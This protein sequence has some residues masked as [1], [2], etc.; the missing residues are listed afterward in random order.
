MPTATVIEIPN[1]G[2]GT[3]LKDIFIAL[4]RSAPGCWTCNGRALQM[5]VWGVD[6]CR[7]HIEEIVAWV[8]EEY[9]KLGRIDTA[10]AVI[11]AATTGLAFS[12]DPRDPPRSLV[13]MAINRAE[14]KVLRA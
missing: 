11:L 2:P 13:E 7:E 8:R 4:G 14:A 9:D 5:N 3:E 12:I 10:K 6:G 1:D